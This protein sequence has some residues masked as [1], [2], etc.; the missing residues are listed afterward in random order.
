VRDVSQVIAAKVRDVG[1]DGQGP[2]LCN[3]TRGW[4]A[5]AKPPHRAQVWA[6]DSRLLSWIRE[7]RHLPVSSSRRPPVNRWS[8]SRVSNE[9]TGYPL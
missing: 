3:A 8:P 7:R 9:N 1:R 4:V 2:L 5:G 6:A